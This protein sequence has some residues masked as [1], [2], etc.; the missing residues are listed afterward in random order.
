MQSRHIL[1]SHKQQPGQQKTDISS[2]LGQT[3]SGTKSISINNQ[4]HWCRWTCTW[5]TLFL[6]S[7]AAHPSRVRCSTISSIQQFA[8]YDPQHPLTLIRR[9]QFPRKLGRGESIWSICKTVLGWDTNTNTQL[10]RIPENR[11]TK[12]HKDLTDI[13][14]YTNKVS[15][16]KCHKL[17]E[18]I[19]RITPFPQ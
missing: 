11:M 3:P 12:V 1:W 14:P 10:L 9:T 2:P 13:P 16:R 19:R 18:F 15:R 4:P 8:F 6:S 5:M 7:R 17:L